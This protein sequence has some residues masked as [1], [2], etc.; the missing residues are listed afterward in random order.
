LIEP[1]AAPAINPT[2]SAGARLQPAMIN[3]PVERPLNA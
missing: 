3:M 2:T 1:I